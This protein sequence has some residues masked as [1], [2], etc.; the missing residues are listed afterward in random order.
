VRREYAWWIFLLSVISYLYTYMGECMYVCVYGYI[1]LCALEYIHTHCIYVHGERGRA[2][3]RKGRNESEGGRMDKEKRKAQVREKIREK[4]Q[5]TE[6]E[7][8]QA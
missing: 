2:W 4:E 7:H 5:K 3:E 8:A 1:C 6:R